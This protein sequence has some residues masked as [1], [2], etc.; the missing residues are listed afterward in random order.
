MH[1][2]V[3]FMDLV[4]HKL[5]NLPSNLFKVYAATSLMLAGNNNFLL[6]LVCFWLF[7][8]CDEEWKCSGGISNGIMGKQF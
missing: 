3:M 2:A 5:Q 6:H 4:L 7:F 8:Q 1:L